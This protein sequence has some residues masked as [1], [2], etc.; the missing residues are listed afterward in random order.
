MCYNVLKGLF[1]LMMI[2]CSSPNKEKQES[3]ELFDT[4]IEEE[5][6]PLDGLPCG[7]D[8]GELACDFKYLDQHGNEVRL[9]DFYEKTIILDLSTAWCYYCNAA[10]Y[11][12][13]Q[14]LSEIPSEDVVWVTV[15]VESREHTAPTVENCAEWAQ[16]Y[17][18]EQP[19]LA[20]CVTLSSIARG[21]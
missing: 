3:E 21:R 14:V 2:G 15:L 1:F 19:V 17:S 7:Y 8:I 4:Q 12:E 9:Y 20:L 10:A 5:P 11:Y 6:H 16:Q 18:L 13:H